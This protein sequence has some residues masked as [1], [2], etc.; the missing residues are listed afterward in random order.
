MDQILGLI[1]LVLDA[2]VLWYAWPAAA[3]GGRKAWFITLALFFPLLSWPW[4]AWQGVRARS[5]RMD[6]EERLETLS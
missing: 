5:A 4:I 1:V 3:T 6:E 2:G